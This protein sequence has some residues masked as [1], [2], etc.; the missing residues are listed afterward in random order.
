MQTWR[1]WIATSASAITPPPTWDE[2]RAR[3]RHSLSG[4]NRQQPSQ[5]DNMPFTE[6]E[7]ARLSFVRWLYLR[8]CLDPAQT[9]NV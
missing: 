1:G 5:K 8:G 2:W 4:E 6:R 9:N 3:Q 7:L